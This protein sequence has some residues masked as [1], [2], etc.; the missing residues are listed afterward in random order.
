MTF[1]LLVDIDG[2]LLFNDEDQFQKLYFGLLGETLHPW[3]SA[4]RLKAAVFE[5]GKRSMEKDTPVNTMEECFDQA[6]YSRLGIDKAEFGNAIENFFT[7]AF[8]RLRSTTRPVPGAREL[9]E[10]AFN[11]GWD[12]VVATNPL[13]PSITTLQRLEWAQI[14]VSEFP[15]RLITTYEKFH[16]CKPH[17][18]Y[19]AEILGH[20]LWPETPVVMIGNSLRDD[21][22]PA[23]KLGLPT[24][25]LNGDQPATERN[26]LSQTGTINGVLPWLEKIEIV[27]PVND[28]LSD[29]AILA[30]LQSTPAVLEE[31]SRG[32]EPA[33]WSHRPAENEWNLIEIL[34]H[35]RDIDRDVNVDRITATL[36]G[37]NPFLPAVDTDTWVQERNYAA[38][39]GPTV[40][41]GFMQNRVKLLSLLKGIDSEA[42]TKPA[43][44]AIFGPTTLKELLGFIATHDRTH[45]RQA[46]K[47]I[48]P[49]INGNMQEN[50]F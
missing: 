41:Q 9:I 27:Q 39:D 31:M 6:F 21:I 25:W 29:S 14:P 33:G 30:T 11:R 15:Y 48:H 32:L 7:T 44:H 24:Y 37:D 4:E 26:P 12:V 10:T 20:L 34:A 43:R 36:R 46:Y 35:L 3:V 2:T 49:F 22:L 40:M 28:Y 47:T 1:T 17:P 19:F 23:E 50:D 5:A 8:P 38:E 13:L 45:I 18:A 42:M 16:F